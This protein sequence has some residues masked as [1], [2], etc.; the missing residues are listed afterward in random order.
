[1]PAIRMKADTTEP[2]RLSGKLYA[3]DGAEGWP[4]VRDGLAEWEYVPESKIGALAA[5][6][7]A[8]EPAPATKARTERQQQP[9]LPTEEEI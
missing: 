3:V 8:A 1:M 2:R 7:A 5:A 9:R 6:E 4:I